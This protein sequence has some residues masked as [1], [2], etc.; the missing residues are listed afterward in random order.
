[1][2]KM[3]NQDYESWT[4]FREKESD[5]LEKPEIDLVVNLHAKYF[6]HKV[7]Y[8]CSCSPRTY[9]TWISELNDIY[10]NGN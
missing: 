9:N 10:A 4:T 8:P 7:K 3:S 5:R 1:M 2:K 6:N